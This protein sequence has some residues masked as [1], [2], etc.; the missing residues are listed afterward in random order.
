MTEAKL[1]PNLPE[2]MV[3]HANRYISSG[4][5]EGHLYKMTSRAARR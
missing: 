4:G 1:A 3:A 5:A 2:W